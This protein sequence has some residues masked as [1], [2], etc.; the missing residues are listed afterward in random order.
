MSINNY[1]YIYI[2]IYIHTHTLTHAC[3]H[4]YM[5][6][7][8]RTCNIHTPKLYQGHLDINV[9]MS[10]VCVCICKHIISL[11]HIIR[12]CMYTCIQGHTKYWNPFSSDTLIYIYIN[13]Y[14]YIHAYHHIVLIRH[15]KHTLIYIHTY[16]H[17]YIHTH[18]YTHTHTHTYLHIPS[19][20]DMR[21]TR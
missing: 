9:Y 8:I 2:Y 13:I 10:D 17:A 16:I 12:V 15:E 19:S 11:L 7:H 1:I 20:S 18:I 14:M 6:T 3:V 4:I 21:S 5:H